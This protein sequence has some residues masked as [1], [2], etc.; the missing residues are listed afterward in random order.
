M[1]GGEEY[2]NLGL[3]NKRSPNGKKWRQYILQ[4]NSSFDIGRKDL[5]ISDFEEGAKYQ[6]PLGTYFLLLEL[7]RNDSQ[8]PMGSSDG[9]G[10]WDMRCE[11]DEKPKSRSAKGLKAHFSV[12]TKRKN[13]RVSKDVYKGKRWC[14]GEESSQ[15]ISC[16]SHH[17][18]THKS[19]H[20][21]ALFSNLKKLDP[22]HCIRSET[23]TIRE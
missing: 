10:I 7:W 3:D 1:G 6:D 23:K 13:W 19:T 4:L 2:R 18:T 21:S 20:S 9:Y 11:V 12:L 17:H 15:R 16:S 14:G 5:N 8:N 22:H